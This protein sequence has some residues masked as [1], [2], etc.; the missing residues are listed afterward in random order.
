MRIHWVLY[1]FKASKCT[2]WMHHYIIIVHLRCI[3]YTM[4]SVWLHHYI[5]ITHIHC[6]PYIMNWFC[7]SILLRIWFKKQ[8][9]RF[10]HLASRHQRLISQTQYTASL[11][12]WVNQKDY[13]NAYMS[14]ASYIYL[15]M[16]MQT[17][18]AK[19]SECNCMRRKHANYEF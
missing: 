17:N 7:D 18:D 16:Q 12:H 19:K 3:Y 14:H 13:H 2:S 8:R 1:W 11:H 9:P 6:I 4:R 15:T 10:S 5:I